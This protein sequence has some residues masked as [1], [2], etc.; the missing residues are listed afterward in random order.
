MPTAVMIESSAKTTSRKVICTT[1]EKKVDR[2]DCVLLLVALEHVV[3]LHRALD[4][5]E[6]AA[7]KQ[8]HV[9]PGDIEADE[10]QDRLR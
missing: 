8:H 6:G 9:P 7:A 5:Q 10:C 2:A 4:D 3:R 1:A